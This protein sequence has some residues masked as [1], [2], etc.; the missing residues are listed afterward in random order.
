MTPAAPTDIMGRVRAS[1][2]DSTVMSQ[3]ERMRLTRSALPLASLT[4][5]MLGCLASSAMVGTAISQEV[6]PGDVVEHDGEA[7]VGDGGEVLD[8]AGLRGLVVVGGDLEGAVRADFFGA[9]GE[10]E[11]FG[12]GVGAGAGEDFE[13]AGGGFHGD[14]DDFDVF[15][16]VQRGGFA[17]GAD[18]HQTIH[19]VGHLKFNQLAQALVVDFTRAVER[20][21]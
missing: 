15:V 20:C 3:T 21:D 18:R 11:G 17:G 19:A 9:A 12:G 1:S 14:A 4:P 7:D 13:A 16:V 8:E 6:R 5:T 2:P 10:V